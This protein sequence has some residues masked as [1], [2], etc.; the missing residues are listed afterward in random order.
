MAPAFPVPR[1]S[2]DIPHP[3]AG[4]GR[5]KVGTRDSLPR[6]CGGT[7]EGTTLPSPPTQR[8]FHLS[9]N[10]KENLLLER[11]GSLLAPI[12]ILHSGV[13]EPLRSPKAVLFPCYHT[14]PSQNRALLFTAL[15]QPCEEGITECDPYFKH[16]ED[17]L[18][19]LIQLPCMSTVP[20]HKHLHPPISRVLLGAA[21]GS[22]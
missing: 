10:T 19:A 5:G 1:N 13:L 14:K 20:A 18:T 11:H 21:A 4:E 15:P 22:G 7:R 17:A 16:A 6:G 8:S 3:G 9:S 2:T 12:Q